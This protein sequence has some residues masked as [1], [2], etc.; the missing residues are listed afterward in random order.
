VVVVEEWCLA[1][2]RVQKGARTYNYFWVNELFGQLAARDARVAALWAAMPFRDAKQQN[3]ESATLHGRHG[4]PPDEAL[5][6]ALATAPGNV[7]KLSHHGFPPHGPLAPARAVELAA[8]TTGAAVMAS[9]LH[10][11]AT[12]IPNITRAQ[13][14]AN[15]TLIAPTTDWGTWDTHR[16]MYIDVNDEAMMDAASAV[17]ARALEPLRPRLALHLV[18]DAA[19]EDN[20]TAAAA[21][22]AALL[23][24]VGVARYGRVSAFL[25]AHEARAEATRAALRAVL[26][27]VNAS[28]AST[29]AGAAPD[30]VTVRGA[31]V[32]V[33]HN[34]LRAAPG[35]AFAAHLASLHSSPAAHLTVLVR[36]P[37]RA[38]AE[39][40]AALANLTAGGARVRAL[41]RVT[42]CACDGYCSGGGSASS[43]SSS[44]AE[45]LERAVRDTY[46]MARRAP[47]RGVFSAAL[48][49]ALAVSAAGVAHQPR[50]FY[51]QLAQ[52]LHLPAAR[53]DGNSNERAC[54]SAGA[55]E[56][57]M[58]RDDRPHVEAAAP[59]A[60][61]AD[62]LWPV[63]FG[64]AHLR[65]GACAELL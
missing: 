4:L 22:L 37:A 35:A 60:A 38:P 43:S 29:E 11:A 56:P 44:A 57:T 40:H 31:R 26:P 63:V 53:G 13:V 49:G 5:L 1:P 64:C 17:A 20:A 15:P 58:M 2:C 62:R 59:F 46:A 50:A 36:A 16:T 14:L 28:G 24:N 7:I 39:L 23:D 65:D 12:R 34:P 19:G 32:L 6:E 3:G 61:A 47:C 54:G 52:L 33:L 41:G 51:A 9:R 8:T 30:V 42:A 10:R 55:D 48:D 45:G 27:M 18:L 25:Y 21:L